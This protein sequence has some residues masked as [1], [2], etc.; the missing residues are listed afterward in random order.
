MPPHLTHFK[1]EVLFMGIFDSLKN[2]TNQAVKNNVSKAV[3]GAVNNA[4]HKSKTFVFADYPKNAD[5][6]KKMPELDFS[7]PLST[8]AF[9]MLVLLEYDESPENT[10]EML[11]VLKGPQPMN[12]MDVQFLR[13]RIRG[14]GYIPRSYFEGS[15]VKNDYTPNVPYKITVSEYAYTYQSE[16][17]AK[18]QVQS[19]GADSPRPIEL[20][21]KGNQWFLWRNLALSDIRTPASVDPW[22]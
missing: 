4:M 18:V 9:A 3:S 6:L 17:Y 15:S 5:E 7:S 1:K 20:R 12:G 16:G 14:R 13:D 10:I 22:A 11:N 19:S 8:A 21:R 2:M